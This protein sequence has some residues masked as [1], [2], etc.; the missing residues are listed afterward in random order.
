MSRA[1]LGIPSLREYSAQ[2]DAEARAKRQAEKK[3][4]LSRDF[5]GTLGSIF[6]QS[7]EAAPERPLQ[8]PPL[9]ASD[10]PVPISN[11]HNS[12]ADLYFHDNFHRFLKLR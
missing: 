8:V 11:Q 3:R 1:A 2:A 10:L 7:G 5:G 6:S 9:D 4:G 12:Q